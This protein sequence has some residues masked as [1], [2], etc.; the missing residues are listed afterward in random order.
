MLQRIPMNQEAGWKFARLAQV[1]V[2]QDPE[3]ALAWSKSID[4]E[5]VRMQTMKALYRAW[6]VDDL[7]DAYVA[8]NDLHDPG[9]RRSVFHGMT[10]EVIKQ[11]LSNDSAAGEAW[12]REWA[13]NL[14]G[15]ER[16]YGLGALA[17]EVALRDPALA[18]DYFAEALNDGE[19]FLVWPSRQIGFQ[20]ASV[21]PASAGEWVKQLPEG[22]LRQHAAEGVARA[23]VAAD[24]ESAMEW[25]ETLPDSAARDGSIYETVFQIRSA[26]PSAAFRLASTVTEDSEKRHYLLKEAVEPWSSF[27][28]QAAMAAIE[29]LPSSI[30]DSERGSLVNL[31]EES[32]KN[33]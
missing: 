31:V 7:E 19:Q 26:D 30:T 13:R 20:Y 1:W 2:G 11:K 16:R 27:A 23:W 22:D 25:I 28:P 29:N 33:R 12:A 3:R 17:A 24:P 14:E 10:V 6:A 9:F 15:E 32:R 21:D 5:A 18:T 8:L 4:F